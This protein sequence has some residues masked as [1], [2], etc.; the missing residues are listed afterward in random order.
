MS[1]VSFGAQVVARAFLT[2]HIAGSAAN[3][4]AGIRGEGGTYACSISCFVHYLRSDRLLWQVLTK[5]AI[6]AITSEE[7]D[8]DS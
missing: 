4:G 1:D 5:E 2:W 6:D 3:P 7:P 8:E